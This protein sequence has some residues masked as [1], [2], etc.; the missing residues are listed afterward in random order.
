MPKGFV[1]P[2]HCLSRRLTGRLEPEFDLIMSKTKAGMTVVDVGANI[3]VYAYGFLA[4]GANVVAIEPQNEGA[5]LIRA[6]YAAGFPR[7]R[8]RGSLDVRQEA[9]GDAEG[10]A[11]LHV[12]LKN[13]KQDAES[14][15]LESRGGGESVEVEVIVRPLDSYGLDNVQIIKMDVEG[16]EIAALRGATR[17][18]RRWKPV[19][20]VEIEQRHHAEPIADVFAKIGEIVGPDY[21]F[22][23]LGSDKRL[24]PLSEFDVERQQLSLADN[25]LDSRY[26]RN[27]F[28][29]SGPARS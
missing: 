9:V 5:D 29:M 22:F 21:G 25:P 8:A 4:R 23:F 19:I 18:I 13:G 16:H 27:F 14:A 7:T 2:A 26:V 6:F 3:G 24:R 20:L 15:S 1:T 28:I 12:P 11:I 17:T 10:K